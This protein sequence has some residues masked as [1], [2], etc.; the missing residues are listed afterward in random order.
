MQEDALELCRRAYDL[1]GRGDFDAM[2]EL[3]A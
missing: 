1:Y 3:F 2:L